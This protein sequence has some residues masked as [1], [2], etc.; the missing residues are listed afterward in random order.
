VVEVILSFRIKVRIVFVL[1]IDSF[2]VLF[3]GCGSCLL[4]LVIFCRLWLDTVDG[5]PEVS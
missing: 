4:S 1:D 5:G 3:E 2:A